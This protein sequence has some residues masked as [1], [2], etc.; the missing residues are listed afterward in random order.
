MEEEGGHA[1]A[2]DLDDRA[3]LQRDYLLRHQLKAAWPS[4]YRRLA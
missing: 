3:G 2:E 4:V 1:D